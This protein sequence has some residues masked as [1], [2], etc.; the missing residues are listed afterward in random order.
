[1]ERLPTEIAI[2]EQVQAF[3]RLTRNNRDP[4]DSNLAGRDELRTC[5]RIRTIVPT[6][7]S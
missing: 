6:T 5:E 7:P 1:M 2:R 4:R 3:T